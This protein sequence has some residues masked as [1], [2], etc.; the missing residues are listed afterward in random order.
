LNETPGVIV[1]AVAFYKNNALRDNIAAVTDA[2]ERAFPAPVVWPQGE[3]WTAGGAVSTS[4]V[5]GAYQFKNAPSYEDAKSN[6]NSSG[7]PALLER[8]E[9]S[10]AFFDSGL[11]LDLRSFPDA[12]FYIP[13]GVGP[14]EGHYPDLGGF[15]V[16]LKYREFDHTISNA[17]ASMLHWGDMTSYRLHFMLA[18]QPSGFVRSFANGMTTLGDGGG[19][20][21]EG[22]M[23]MTASGGYWNGVKEVAVTNPWVVMPDRDLDIFWMNI[24]GAARTNITPPCIVEAFAFYRNDALGQNIQAITDAMAQI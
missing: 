4:D 18:R 1:E 15:G 21:M 10:N 20:D 19:P 17:N 11:G 7:F 22:I 6:L 8:G 2:M 12:G 5:L 9:M 3:W 23:A 13:N 16:I 14:T 24:I